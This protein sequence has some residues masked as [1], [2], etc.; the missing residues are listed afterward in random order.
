M[1]RGDVFVLNAPYAGGTH[2]PDVTVV[3]PVFIGDASDVPTF[4]VAAR[5]HHA[6]IGG[7]TPGSMPAS[8]THIEEEGVLLDNV[9]LVANGVFLEDE[10]RRLLTSGKYPARNVEQNLADLRAQVAACQKGAAELENMVAHFGL[11]VVQAYMQHVQNNA[12]EAVR[13]VIGALKDGEFT[14]AMDNGAQ[15]KVSI[16]IDAKAREAVIDFSGTSAQ[17]PNNFNAPLPVT[18]AAVLYV[19]RTLVD[20]EIPM[21]AGCLKPLRIVVPP[22]SMINPRA[23]AAVVAGNVETSQ[24]SPI[25]C[26]ARSAC[27]LQVRAR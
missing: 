23:P 12:E 2:L 25:V 10:M 24:W 22:G 17:Q 6:D 1:Q 5:G 9:Q 3:M 7:T 11:P 20:D 19:F 14:Y 13:R 27:S 15:V 4:F 21:N 26:T 8:S 18:R 16:R